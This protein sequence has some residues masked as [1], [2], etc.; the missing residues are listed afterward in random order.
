MNDLREWMEEITR[1]AGEITLRYFNKPNLEIITKSDASPV[2]R[3][4][5]ESEEY[6]RKRIRE[7]FPDDKILGEEFGEDG[8]SESRRWILDPIDGTQSFIRGVPLYGVMIALEEG[9]I[10]THGCVHFPALNEIISARRGHGCFWNA[11]RCQV[12]DIER[13]ED[14]TLL[15]TDFRRL[16]GKL[17]I[18]ARDVIVRKA[19]T[20]RGWGDCY[21]HFLVATGRADIM[22]DPKVAMWDTAPIGV[23]VEEAGGRAFDFSGNDT[24]YSPTLITTNS[25]LAAE[26]K[27]MLRA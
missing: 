25:E 2:T 27:E 7:H 22:L 18:V 10:I 26:V 1:G 6:L 11:E 24:V 17:S 21:G 13:I 23:I 9:G 14:A 12:S 3:A 20:V 16:E 5:R 15:A 8:S 19:K 4:D